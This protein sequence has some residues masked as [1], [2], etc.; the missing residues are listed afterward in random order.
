MHHLIPQLTEASQDLI[1]ERNREFRMKFHLASVPLGWAWLIP[2]FHLPEPHPVTQRVHTLHFPRSQVDFAIGPG[3]A[4]HDILVRLEEV[5]EQE[6]APT[7][8]Q[9]SDDEEWRVGLEIS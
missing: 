3:A 9:L 5:Q 4:I 7:A 8:R 2:A 6:V 1:L